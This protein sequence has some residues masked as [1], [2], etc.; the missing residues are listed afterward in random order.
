M[1]DAEVMSDEYPPDPIDQ[2]LSSLLRNGWFYVGSAF[3]VVTILAYLFW[4]T[5][6]SVNARKIKAKCDYILECTENDK[7]EAFEKGT[8][9][10]DYL[11][12][13]PIK[14]KILIDKISA[15]REFMEIYKPTYLGILQKAANDELERKE[16]IKRDEEIKVSK[17]RLE[18]L[19]N[20]LRKIMNESQ[21]IH[22]IVTSQSNE[23]IFVWGQALSKQNLPGFRWSESSILVRGMK[24]FETV[25]LLKINGF[26]DIV[27]KPR[28]TGQKCLFV[29]A[30]EGKNAL[31]QSVDLY[32]YDYIDVEKL[33][34]EIEF[35]EK[36]INYLQQMNVN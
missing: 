35:Y 21:E 14:S 11:N 3:L 19:R 20:R 29:D 27:S 24:P 32:V 9:L 26:N 7:S 17:I 15:V 31:G 28:M 13:H 16:K 12:G 30:T 34:F 6:E 10:N 5:W 2:W 23:G 22:C 8:E 33:R 4:P 1:R 18:Y 25:T 36:R